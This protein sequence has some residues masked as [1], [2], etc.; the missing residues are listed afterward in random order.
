MYVLG[1]YIIS[2]YAGKPFH[3]FVEERIF[4][5]LNM[6]STTYSGITASANGKFSQPFTFYLNET[7]RIPFAFNTQALSDVIAGPGGIIS[8]TVDMVSEHVNSH[9]RQY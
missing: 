1:S 5:P 3:E 7:R 2:T 9:I 8:N 6:T 4:S